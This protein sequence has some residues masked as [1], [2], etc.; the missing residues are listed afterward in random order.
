MKVQTFRLIQRG[1]YPEAPDWFL[2]VA[3]TINKQLEQLTNLAQKNIT[4]AENT[5]SEERDLEIANDVPFE[6]TLNQ[7]KGKPTKA[8]L[9]WA[10]LFDYP[11]LAWEVISETKVRAKVR[12]DSEPANRVR[13]KILFEAG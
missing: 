3:E 5:N 6:V 10:N 13:V 8:R 7:L 4:A 1:D 2:R 11:H 12:F 9:V